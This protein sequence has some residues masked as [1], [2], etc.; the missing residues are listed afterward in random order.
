MF[1]TQI[2][3]TPLSKAGGINEKGLRSMFN[4]TG[5][6]PRRA[7]ME[8]VDNGIDA[9]ATEIRFNANRNDKSISIVDNG[10]GMNLEEFEKSFELYKEKD[11]SEKNK[12]GKCGYGMK[13]SLDI[14]SQNSKCKMLTRKK[15]GQYLSSII[16]C[17]PGNTITGQYHIYEMSEEE[18]EQFQKDLPEDH[19]TG[20]YFE[21]NDR[22]YETIRE[23]FDVDEHTDSDTLPIS[24]R[25]S[26]KYGEV[27]NFK[28]N[29]SDLDSASPNELL[30]YDPY[31]LSQS[32]Y[33]VASEKNTI[34]LAISAKGDRMV[35]Y[36]HGDNGEYLSFTLNRKE[37][38]GNGNGNGRCNKIVKVSKDSPVKN[39]R[40]F[41]ES[42]IMSFGF[43]L[44]FQEPHQ[45]YF[46]KTKL[47]TSVQ[48]QPVGNYD[49]IIFGNKIIPER[50]NK[51]S[52]KRADVK[53]GEIPFGKREQACGGDSQK[54]KLKKIHINSQLSYEPTTSHSD[55]QDII[56][57][58]QSNKH[59]YICDDKKIQPLIRLCEH[60]RNEYG[61]KC[62]KKMTEIVDEHQK[63]SSQN[64]NS[65]SESESTVSDEELTTQHAIVNTLSE[66]QSES[67]DEVQSV[68]VQETVTEP[69]PVPKSVPRPVLVQELVPESE[70]VPVQVQ[71]PEPV[72]E[73]NQATVLIDD[74]T[75]GKIVDEYC[76]KDPNTIKCL[77][78]KLQKYI[79]E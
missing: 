68:P 2:G 23:Q 21:E 41:P 49:R 29:F 69:E 1:N 55:K 20:I 22:L 76:K 26:Y 31:S 58:V 50:N 7:I 27:T 51:M 36:T 59:Q 38:N 60:L 67:E 13:A 79:V 64:E 56:M 45:E 18:K 4:Y 40:T 30:M 16:D 12:R 37:T 73:Q 14:L 71:E 35:A 11:D 70:P 53:I 8:L 65:D 72:T 19:G 42:D 74:E 24:E 57:G 78:E 44:A 46:D 5:I 61:E 9:N 47:P 3:V 77:V 6:T 52:L 28:M 33:L 43:D 54:N 62:W 39:T 66:S 34:H 17:S 32:E 15:G 48:L 75:V 25:F 10:N 63:Q